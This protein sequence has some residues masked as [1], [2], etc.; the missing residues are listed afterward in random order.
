MPPSPSSR[1]F[2]V[3][4]I[5]TEGFHTRGR[6]LESKFPLRAKDDDLVLF[7]EMQNRE[8]DNFLLHSSDDFDDS[9]CNASTPPLLFVL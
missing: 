6:S 5:R 7:N 8:R 1:R 3:R 2:P 9:I 4:E